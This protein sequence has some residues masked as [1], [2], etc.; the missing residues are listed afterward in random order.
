MKNNFPHGRVALITGASSGIGA[1]AALLFA[2][3]GYTVYGASRRGTLPQ[4]DTPEQNKGRLHALSMD[5]TREDS[6]TAGIEEIV[7][8][9]GRLDILIHAAGDGLSGPIEVSSAEDGRR[10]MDVNYFGALRL[11]NAALPVMRSQGKGLVILVG[12]VGGLFSIPYQTL[13]SSSKAALIMLNNGLRLELAPFNIQS[14]IVLPGDVKTG[15]TQARRQVQAPCPEVYQAAMTRAVSQMER[16][17]QNGMA[18]EKVARLILKTARQRRPGAQV[19]AGGSSRVQ[20]FLNRL[21]P[22]AAVESLI[23]RIYLG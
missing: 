22:H 12:S 20:V 19:I 10:Q 18:P 23:R 2:G 7:R 21:L 13:Y 15:F 4:A 11:L 9:E 14:S 1:A 3:N 16:D 6:V 5:V 8:G 17:E